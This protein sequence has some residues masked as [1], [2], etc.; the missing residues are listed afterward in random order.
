M[1]QPCEA[2]LPPIF[3]AEF[4]SLFRE[5][6]RLNHLRIAANFGKKAGTQGCTPTLSRAPTDMKHSTQ[7]LHLLRLNSLDLSSLRDLCQP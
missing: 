3:P 1:D 6:S 5:P 2:F 7:R 4:F